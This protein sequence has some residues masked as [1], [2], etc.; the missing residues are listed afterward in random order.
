MPESIFA[1]TPS[2]K[3]FELVTSTQTFWE[4]DARHWVTPRPPY[5][6]QAAPS[7]RPRRVWRSRR[8]CRRQLL[9]F[10]DVRAIL[11]HSSG[12][13]LPSATRSRV[14]D[15]AINVICHSPPLYDALDTFGNKQKQNYD[16]LAVCGWDGKGAS[17]ADLN[18][19][20]PSTDTNRLVVLDRQCIR[21]VERHAADDDGSIVLAI[22]HAHHPIECSWIFSIV[23]RSS[24]GLAPTYRAPAAASH[25]QAQGELLSFSTLQT[26]QLRADVPARAG[27]CAFGFT[28]SRVWRETRPSRR[29]DQSV[30]LATPVSCADGA[31]TAGER[32]DSQTRCATRHCPCACPWTVA[33]QF[34]SLSNVSKMSWTL[35]RCSRC[36]TR[37]RRHTARCR[38]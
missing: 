35:L 16:G 18:L 29:G 33:A 28:A 2:Q 31:I 7:T 8:R 4:Y 37:R 1:E 19:D 15:A 22:P 38:C 27:R 10:S 9:K 14:M 24:T 12:A 32:A 30:F 6:S 34:A 23:S 17:L 21:L 3:L 5:S 26:V 25:R 36:S 11:D 13:H 20:K